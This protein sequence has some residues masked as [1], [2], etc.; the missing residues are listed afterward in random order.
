[1]KRVLFII[2]GLVV[3]LGAAGAFFLSRLDADFIVRRIAEATERA[4]GAPLTLETA[5]S[6]SLLPPG[7]RF[8]AARWHGEPGGNAVAVSLQ[9]GMARLELAPLFS[10]NIVISEIR[11][12]RPEAD[13]RLAPAKAPEHVGDAPAST[14]PAAPDAGKAARKA[15]DDA[16]PFELGRL[17][18]TQGA[19]T[20]TDG[21]RVTRVSG[22]NLSLENL[23]RREE[24]S[25]QGDMVLDL[26]EQGAP[27]LSGN[28][29]FKGSLRYYAPNL[30][31][32]QVSLA[33]T[34][35]AGLIP[36]ELAPLQLTGEGA[37]D[38]ASLRL[39]LAEARLT[40][41]QARLTVQGEGTL[42]P[43]AFAGGVQFSGEV[44]ALAALAGL[45][46]PKGAGDSVEA[47]LRLDFSGNSLRLTGLDARGAGLAL[48]GDLAVTLPTAAEAAPA[49]R[50][51]LR[52]GDV[53]LAP[54]LAGE[55][56]ATPAGAKAAPGAAPGNKKPPAP[57]AGVKQS[58]SG[59]PVLDLRLSIAAL[60]YGALGLTDLTTRLTGRAGRYS[61]EDLSTRLT[62]GGS[63]KGTL[64]AD[65]AAAAYRV[66]A[67]GTGVDIGPLC[68]AL[69][70]AGL[71]G[72]TAAF[73]ADLSASGAN[74]RALLASLDGAGTLE[75]R[76]LSAPALRDAAALLKGLP[77]RGLSIPERISAVSAPFTARRG[78]IT[79][80]PVTLTAA[81]L[82]ARGEAAASLT[83]EY[84]EGSATV[85]AA[86][87]N[88]PLTFKGPF[89]D[90]S[91][92]VDPKFA[93]E[94]G[95]KLGGIPGMGNAAG[96]AGS[97]AARGAGNAV[98]DGL[99]A[100]GGIVRGLLGR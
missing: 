37:L 52:L 71:A 7:V 41:P 94:L 51:S 30:T 62:T 92:S 93:L 35:L 1:M 58:R 34:P 47:A 97:G 38:L 80:R 14:A 42:A 86:G 23:R 6:L 21:G 24:T 17:T 66:K 76:D 31:F 49:V 29:A 56:A 78:E 4:T 60:R 69:G 83:R 79:A 48:G 36:R 74:S 12:E 95:A 89:G 68:A 87:L 63:L 72:G 40:T 81:G 65:L 22:F 90:I 96:A 39:N 33:F 8:G 84:L 100:A 20:L 50:G 10:G 27:E 25:V 26:A 46:A 13:I 99:G 91:V 15:P 18:V 85:S 73:S 67:T 53:D 61:L 57:G 54:W 82:S 77:L 44:P 3:L 43:P 16:L 88:I 45:S 28:L 59:L 64:T 70:K 11:L 75:A 5:P 32:R 98:R 2:L 55:K 19:L 9:G